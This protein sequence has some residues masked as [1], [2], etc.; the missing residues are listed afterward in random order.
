MSVIKG[1]NFK[2][3]GNAVVPKLKES[4]IKEITVQSF[5]APYY[6]GYSST[7]NAQTLR[8]QKCYTHTN[9]RRMNQAPMLV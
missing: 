3:W 7:F 1:E 5:T 2:P 8:K 4:I 9:Y 6:T